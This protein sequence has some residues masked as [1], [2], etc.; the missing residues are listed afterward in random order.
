M[1]PGSHNFGCLADTRVQ[2]TKKTK[3]ASTPFSAIEL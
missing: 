1:Y 2:M 3:S